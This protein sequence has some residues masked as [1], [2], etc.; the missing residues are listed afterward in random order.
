[1]HHKTK[2]SKLGRRGAHRRAMLAAQVSS[3][4]L[5]KKITTTQQKAR[6]TRTLAEKMVTLG[7]RG[8][9]A[10]RRRAL[11]ILRQKKAVSILF[12]DIAPECKDRHGGY[13]RMTKLGTRP[14]DS[15]A[16]VQLEWVDVNYTPGKKNTEEASAS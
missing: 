15:S 2:S 5:E 11:S 6:Q 10:A 9:L 14:S 4:I 1:M 7:K 13:T 8:D 16:M 12:D 3:L